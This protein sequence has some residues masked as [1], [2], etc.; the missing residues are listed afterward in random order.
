MIMKMTDD[1]D[2]FEQ[3]AVA[4]FF[5]PSGNLEPLPLDGLFPGLRRRVDST[6]TSD[7]GTRSHI[8]HAKEARSNLQASR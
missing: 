8:L 2:G 7:H 5:A 6:H 3:D 1:G 4:P